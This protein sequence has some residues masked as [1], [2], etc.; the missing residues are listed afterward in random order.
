MDF[1]WQ[2]VKRKEYVF[3]QNEIAFFQITSILH[4]IFNSLTRNDEVLSYATSRKVVSSI[5][6]E[7]I[8]FFNSCNDY[9]AIFPA[10][11]WPWG[12]LNQ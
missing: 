6:H 3:E 12:R 7:V 4:I 9:I 8:R 2:T 1:T 11:L 5:P 10:V